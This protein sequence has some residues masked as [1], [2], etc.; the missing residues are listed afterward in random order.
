MKFF[1]TLVLCLSIDAYTQG[2]IT[3]EDIPKLESEEIVLYKEKVKDNSWPRLKLNV[4]INSTPLEAMAIFLALD[5]QKNYLPNLIKSTPIKHISATEVLTEYELELPW[6]LSNSKYT[7]GSDFKKLSEDSYKA[8][9]YMVKSDSANEVTGSVLFK[10]YKGKTLMQYQ[11]L[12]RP[13]SALSGIVRGFMVKDT[14]EAIES[15]KKET[16]RAKS[17]DKTLMKKYISYIK[18][19]LN[20]EFVYQL[21]K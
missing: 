13:K 19:S 1:L 10:P 16:E 8:T 2:V 11:T 21:K 14:I 7:H 6:P 17:K 15:I 4:L 12:I 5:H 20:G 3:K 18:R 9:W